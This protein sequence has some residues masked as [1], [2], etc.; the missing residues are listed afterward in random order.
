[1]RVTDH[2]GDS[3]RDGTSAGRLV[4]VANA[5]GTGNVAGWLA[6]N[7]TPVRLDGL[8]ANSVLLAMAVGSG[9]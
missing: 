8:T 9:V 5:F 3:H 4:A 7:Q 1:M 6:G 2:A